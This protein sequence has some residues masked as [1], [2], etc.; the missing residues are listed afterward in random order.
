MIDFLAVLRSRNEPLFYFGL[1]CLL[2]AVFVLLI[3]KFSHIQINGVNSWYKPFKFA[4]SIGIF[5]WTMGWY[6]GYLELP[7]QVGTYS[8]TTIILLGFELFYI[9]FQAARG[10]LSHYNVS[11][12]LYTSLTAAMAFAAIAA[13]LYTGYIGILFC[14]K[15]FPELPG[16]YLWAIRIG[17]FLFVVFA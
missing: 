17:I 10:Q 8:W 12:S 11:S 2:S 4:L 16:Y 9:T 1:I 5:S 6:T 13:T 3:A 14:T 7:N 15:E